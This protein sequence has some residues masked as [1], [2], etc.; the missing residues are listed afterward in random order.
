MT[1]EK[2]IRHQMSHKPRRDRPCVSRSPDRPDSAYLM[3]PKDMALED[4]VSIYAD[5]KGRIAFEFSR[6]GE[7]AVRRTSRTSYTVKVTIPRALVAS[8]PF[9]LTDVDLE[10]N[11]EGWLIL[12]P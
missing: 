6:F 7:Y 4:R 1:W 2:V 9:G 8:I 5:K 10:T 12:T 11:S 3:L